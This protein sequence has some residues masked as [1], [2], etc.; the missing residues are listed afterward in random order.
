MTGKENREYK[1]SMFVDIFF[2]DAMAEEN[3]I[4]LYNAL[5]DEPLT[6]GT[7]IQKIRLENVL[8]LNFRNDVSFGVEILILPVS[9]KYW[10][11]A[12]F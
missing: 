1:N 3:E 7:K 6:Q 12:E 11:S 9:M 10:R 2:E 4:S 8:Y 5:H